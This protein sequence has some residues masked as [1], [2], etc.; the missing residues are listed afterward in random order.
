MP[1]PQEKEL[2]PP[3]DHW[4]P[5]HTGLMLHLVRHTGRAAGLQLGLGGGGGGVT[6]C[7][8]GFQPG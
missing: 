7:G 2:P 4:L 1:L 5:P 6:G 3:Y 8:S